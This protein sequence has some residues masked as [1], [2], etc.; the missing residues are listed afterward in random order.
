M[1]PEEREQL[2]LEQ[3][4]GSRAQ[5]AYDGYIQ[6][7]CEEKRAVLFDAFRNLPLTAE[8]DLME[9]KRMLYA[10]DQLEIDITQQIETGKMASQA[11]NKE[12]TQH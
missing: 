9:V 7:F 11:L 6:N 8:A 1:T 10:V 2:E 4:R 12:E 5:N 3:S